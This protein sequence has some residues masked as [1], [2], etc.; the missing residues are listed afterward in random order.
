MSVK[1]FALCLPKMSSVSTGPRINNIQVLGEQRRTT[2][3]VMKTPHV[4]LLHAAWGETFERS[5]G[6][7]G[8]H[9]YWEIP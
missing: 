4:T 8:R 7:F 3:F 2:K 5:D 9:S 6:V 1:K